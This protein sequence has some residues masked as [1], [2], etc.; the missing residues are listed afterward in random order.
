MLRVNDDDDVATH[1]TKHVS[2]K[3][4]FAKHIQTTKQIASTLHRESDNQQRPTLA[5]LLRPWTCYLE[6]LVPSARQAPKSSHSSR[7]VF[8]LGGELYL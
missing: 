8:V 3:K 2:T 6:R 4:A 5:V 1:S 7:E